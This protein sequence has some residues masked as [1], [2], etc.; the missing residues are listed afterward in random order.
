MFASLV[1]LG[2]ESTNPESAGALA[3]SSAGSLGSLVAEASTPTTF[4]VLGFGMLTFVVSG[5]RSLGEALD[6]GLGESSPRWAPLARIAIAGVFFPWALAVVVS[7]TFSP[8]LYFR[9]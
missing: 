9:F 3:G 7:G 8:F 4:L 6:P 5:Q 1:G 2:S